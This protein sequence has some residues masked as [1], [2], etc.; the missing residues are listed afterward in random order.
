MKNW[1]FLK[2]ALV[3]LSVLSTSKLFADDGCD[4]DKIRSNAYYTKNEDLM[5]KAVANNC[6]DLMDTILK[7]EKEDDIFR[8]TQGFMLNVL[9]DMSMSLQGMKH[10]D[11]DDPRAVAVNSKI[12]IIAKFAEFLKTKCPKETKG[13]DACMAQK[14][15]KEYATKLQDKFATLLAEEKEENK[16]AEFGNSPEGLIQKACA[17]DKFLDNNQKIL[18]RQKE[19]GKVSGT[20]NMVIL[21][22]AGSNIVDLK[23]MK[24]DVAAKYK[25][26]AKKELKNYKC[27]NT[28]QFMNPYLDGTTMR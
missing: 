22:S 20:V 7:K 17:Y 5:A 13:S 19:I 26:V 6:P 25:A 24:R 4:Y 11:E 1:S 15:F 21:N 14:T 28:D 2:I 9:E 27:E 12:K 16:A 3:T 18:D 23:K 10:V 8:A